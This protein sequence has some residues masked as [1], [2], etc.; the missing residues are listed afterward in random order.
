MHMPRYGAILETNTKQ[1]V[2]GRDNWS[3]GK[4]TNH[5]MRHVALESIFLEHASE[6]VVNV[7]FFHLILKLMNGVRDGVSHPNA[8]CSESVTG[9][10]DLQPQNVSCRTQKEVF[11]T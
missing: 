4:S 6:P 7:L 1:C 10:K 11:Y 9:S 8:A 5:I 3:E 2:H